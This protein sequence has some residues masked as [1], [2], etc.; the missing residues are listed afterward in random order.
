M[1][2]A[3]GV[4]ENAVRWWTSMG[5]EWHDVRRW[6][7]GNRNLL[8]GVWRSTR[9]NFIKRT[10]VEAACRAEHQH[11]S[12]RQHQ[13]QTYPSFPSHTTLFSFLEPHPPSHDQA[14]PSMEAKKTLLQTVFSNGS[15]VSDGGRGRVTLTRTATIVEPNTFCSGLTSLVAEGKHHQRKVASVGGNGRM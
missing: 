7:A 5:H 2:N 1:V 10:M 13:L 4:S 6:G 3:L 9:Q 15:R 8:V 12:T 14:K 11:S